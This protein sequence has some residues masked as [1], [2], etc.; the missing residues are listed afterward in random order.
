MDKIDLPKFLQKQ[1]SVTEWFSNINHQNIELI[2]SEE[3]SR[4][5]RLELLNHIIGLPFDKAH[6]FPALEVSQNKSNFK[7]FFSKHQNELCAIRLIPLDPKLPKLR[8]RGYTIKDA[9]SWFKEQ[10]I[11]PSQYRVDFIPHSNNQIWATIFIVNDQGI[12]GEM[13]KGGHYQLTQGFYD[14]GEPI[15]FS[16]NWKKWQF[17]KKVPS[18]IKIIKEVVE[19]IRVENTAKQKQLIEKLDVQ[20]TNNYLQGYF[21][22]LTTQEYGLW[23]IDYNRVM[24]KMYEDFSFSLSDNKS[25]HKI[26]KGF[27]SSK[28]KV[29]G[30]AKI[31]TPENFSGMKILEEEIL[32][33]QMTTPDYLPLMQKAAAIVTDLGGVL[34]HAAIISRELGKPCITNTK[35]AT[36]FFQNGDLIEVDANLGVIRKI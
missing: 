2:R 25:N 1:V 12:F 18:L 14:V 19:K 32:I 26:I 13:T 28:G 35:K 22:A 3:N 5:Q 8:M 36:Q 7:N 27:I 34:S 11:D 6:Q 15:T 17:S 20:F 29:S 9:L 33:C 10:N 24:G 4:S 21:E 23:F 16:F 30:K 31:I